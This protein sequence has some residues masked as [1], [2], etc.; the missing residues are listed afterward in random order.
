MAKNKVPQEILQ[1]IE[2]LR[3]ELDRYNKAYYEEDAPL[4]SD[5]IF[6]EKMKRLEALEAEHPS[7]GTPQSPTQKVGGAAVFAPTDHLSPMLSLQNVFGLQEL[8]EFFERVEK[9]LDGPVPPMWVEPKIDGL[10][11]SLVYERG[12]LRRAVTRGDGQTGENVTR[13]AMTLGDIPRRLEG[14]VPPVVE[15]R[16]EVFMTFEGFNAVNRQREEAGE[17]LF[18]NPRNCAAGS[19]RQKDWRVTESRP[20]RFRAHSPGF[21]FE[22]GFQRHSEIAEQLVAWGF[23]LPEESGLFGNR[24]TITHQLLSYETH[25]ARWAYPIDGGVAKVDEWEQ[26]DLL[27]ATSKFPRW[28]MAFKFQQEVAET[29]LLGVEWSVGRTGAVTPVAHLSPVQLAGTTVKRATLHNPVDMARRGVKIGDT[30]RVAKAGEI[31]PEILGVVEKKRT[32]DETDIPIPTQCPGCPGRHVTLIQEEAVL[33]C[34]STDCEGQLPRWV[35]HFASR[36]AMDIDGLG[37]VLVDQLLSSGLVNNVADLYKLKAEDVMGL[38]RMAQK[39]A[40]NLM[41]ALEKSKTT[42]LGRF[43]FALGIRGVG[44]ATAHTLADHFGDLQKVMAATV[45]ELE[46]VPDVGIVIAQ[47]IHDTFQSERMQEIVA[48]LLEAGVTPVVERGKTEGPLVGKKAVVTGSFEGQSRSAIQEWLREQ[49]A[50][51]QSSM[52]KATDLLIVGE[53]PGSKLEKAQKLSI[54]TVDAGGLE[55]LQQGWDPFAE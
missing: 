10:G 44:K 20:L 50:V 51:V 17:A 14:D 7:T 16:G 54:T 11:L 3:S 5:A 27:G 45:E 23:T 8:D 32:G 2:A 46:A 15:I 29:T 6:D 48:G 53:K 12:R 49:G 13:S 37:S 26:R 34:P 39:S 1:E 4:V 52:G 19:L 18:A 41:A 55:K 24:D 38:E 28:A 21:G 9:G 43:L 47:E 35:R 25:R 36:D 22:E 30:V 33:R 40:D 42:T 31:I